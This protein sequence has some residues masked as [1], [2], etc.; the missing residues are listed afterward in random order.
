MRYIE[1]FLSAQKTFEKDYHE[2]DKP[3][4]KISREAMRL[5][6]LMISQRTPKAYSYFLS[7]PIVQKSPG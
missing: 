2:F 1:V 6:S 5:P 3:K 7:K 4:C